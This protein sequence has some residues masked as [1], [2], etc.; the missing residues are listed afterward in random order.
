MTSILREWIL[1]KTKN[2]ITTTRG[3]EWN[4]TWYLQLM[5]FSYQLQTDSF[6]G[7]YM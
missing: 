3:T 4:K 2:D 1:A 6:V 5:H 7:K